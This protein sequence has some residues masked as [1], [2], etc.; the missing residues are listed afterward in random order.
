M[1]TRSYIVEGLGNVDSFCSCSHGAGRIKSRS[2]AK[3]AFTTKDAEKQTKGIVCRKD[4]GI[5][6]ELPGAY[7]NID[8]VMENQKDLVKVVAQLR[9]ILCVKG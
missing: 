4:E 9:Q 1:G 3:S 6:D 7:K 5:L 8:Q 2:K